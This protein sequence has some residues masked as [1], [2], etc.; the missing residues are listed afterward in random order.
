MLS[1]R[2]GSNHKV[3]DYEVQFESYKCLVIQKFGLK[4]KTFLFKTEEF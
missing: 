3:S 4:P 2:N 1:T